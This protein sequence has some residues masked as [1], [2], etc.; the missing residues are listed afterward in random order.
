MKLIENLMMRSACFLKRLVLFSILLFILSYIL[1]QDPLFSTLMI[2]SCILFLLLSYFFYLSNVT[3]CRETLFFKIDKKGRKE[4]MID[5]D[6][7]ALYLYK[8]VSKCDLPLEPANAKEFALSIIYL[9]DDHLT[10]Y[11]KCPKAH[12]YKTIKKGKTLKERQIIK[13]NCDKNLEFYYSYI[14][15]V[16]FDK[17]SKKIYITLN[18]GQQE[19]IEC[20]KTPAKK[21]VNAIREKLR[22]SER[23][24]VEHA[25]SSY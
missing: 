11:T 10:I 7:K 20:G 18:S 8:P 5:E 3:N 6:S 1:Y 9:A 23:E 24:W 25:R 14:Q 12:I 19:E 21:A 22:N 13:D 2:L 17:S 15:S 4:L 16:H